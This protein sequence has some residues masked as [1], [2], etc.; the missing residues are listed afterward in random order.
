MQPVRE[1]NDTTLPF[2]WFD[3]WN[4]Q[5]CDDPNAKNAFA[6]ALGAKSVKNVRTYDA[7]RRSFYD[8]I[9]MTF[10]FQ[11]F[12]TSAS[13]QSTPIEGIFRF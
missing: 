3:V 2:Q 6:L 9:L 11:S 10:H 5:Q 7:P 12:L 8:V 4:G 1:Q 13:E